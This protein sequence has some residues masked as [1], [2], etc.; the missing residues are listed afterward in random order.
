[1]R[2]SSSHFFAVFDRNVSESECCGEKE[3]KEWTQNMRWE[4]P[5]LS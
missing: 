4:F 5:V 2:S 3:Q 1:M